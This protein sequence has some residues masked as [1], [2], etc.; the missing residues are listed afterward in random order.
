MRKQVTVM[1]NKTEGKCDCSCSVLMK[2]RSPDDLEILLRGSSGRTSNAEQIEAFSS[3][4]QRGLCPAS[5]LFVF[6]FP[7]LSHRGTPVTV[8]YTTSHC[9]WATCCVRM[10]GSRLW[11]AERL[12]AGGYWIN[13]KAKALRLLSAIHRYGCSC[14]SLVVVCNLQPTVLLSKP[15]GVLGKVSGEPSRSALF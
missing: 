5:P 8:A 13:L 11:S 14:A 7:I 3:V 2:P 10:C 1:V 12:L 4:M 9:C 15:Q 6:P